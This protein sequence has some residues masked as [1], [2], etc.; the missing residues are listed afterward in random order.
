VVI[1]AVVTDRVLAALISLV[2]PQ[3]VKLQAAAGSQET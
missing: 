1:L 2:T 3:G